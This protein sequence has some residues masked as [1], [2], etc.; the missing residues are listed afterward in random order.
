MLM[1]HLKDSAI[2][3]LKALPETGHGLSA[4][5]S[6]HLGKEHA[7][8]GCSRTSLVVIV[9]VSPI[10]PTLPGARNE[11]RGSVS[12]DSAG[13]FWDCVMCSVIRDRAQI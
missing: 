4:G 2:E 13:A 9:G 3:S 10:G 7:V 5:R 6:G 8:V 11:W 1:W 12:V